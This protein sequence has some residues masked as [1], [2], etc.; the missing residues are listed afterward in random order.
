MTLGRVRR[1][2]LPLVLRVKGSAQRQ[3]AELILD[4]HDLVHMATW[5]SEPVTPKTLER[6]RGER[7]A[8]SADK[9]FYRIQAWLRLRGIRFEKRYS[10]EAPGEVV[11]EFDAAAVRELIR[12][13][14]Q[15]AC[16]VLRAL[17]LSSRRQRIHAGY[18]GADP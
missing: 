5:S 17:D 7:D 14:V 16:R 15:P 8:R 11:L 18:R 10:R 12:R 9:A 6:I 13:E 4:L 1:H 3:L 2:G